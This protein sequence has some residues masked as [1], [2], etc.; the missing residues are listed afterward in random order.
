MPVSAHRANRD[1]NK[2]HT[3]EIITIIIIKNNECPKSPVTLT[4]GE[5]VDMVREGAVRLK[6]TGE[7]KREEGWRGG[8]TW[9]KR[10]GPTYN[11]QN[12]RAQDI[13]ERAP[14]QQG[15]P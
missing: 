2:N 14:G 15:E 12:E 11:G 1:D 6:G 3:D 8:V 10:F 7:N 13:P 9:V 5:W 4:V